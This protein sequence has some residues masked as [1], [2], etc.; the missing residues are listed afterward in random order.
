[1]NTM[2]GQWPPVTATRGSWLVQSRS[3]RTTLP[4][5]SP[6]LSPSTFT[7]RA[8]L[9]DYWRQAPAN[10]RAIVTAFR[11]DGA[12]GHAFNLDKLASEARSVRRRTQ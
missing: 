11:A 6:A 2:P 5:R 8:A 7:T 3:R 1:M 12:I 9:L 4:A 10:A